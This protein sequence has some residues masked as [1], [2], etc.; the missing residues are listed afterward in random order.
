MGYFA[1]AWNHSG[2]IGMVFL[3]STALEII[4]RLYRKYPELTPFPPGVAKSKGPIWDHFGV[5]VAQVWG[6]FRVTFGGH[7]R[8]TSG[9]TLESPWDTLGSL[10]WPL[11]ASLVGINLGSLRGH[12]GYVRV[13]LESFWSVF[14]KY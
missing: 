9:V 10:R 12:F 7:F 8:I 2:D 5:A 1:A 3:L 6:H 14:E 11:W 4:R 13:T